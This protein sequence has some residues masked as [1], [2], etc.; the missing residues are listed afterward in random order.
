VDCRLLDLTDID[1][2][3][4]DFRRL[5]IDADER[6]RLGEAACMSARRILSGPSYAE[7]FRELLGIPAVLKEAALA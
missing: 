4:A 7:R 5:L 6:A 3:A 1:A 2:A